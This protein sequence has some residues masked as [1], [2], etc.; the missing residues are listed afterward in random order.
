MS[1]V[2][3]LSRVNVPVYRGRLVSATGP[4]TR[5]QTA[6]RRPPSLDEC[7]LITTS[8]P[9]NWCPPSAVCCQDGQETW[10]T[11][12]QLSPNHQILLFHS[13]EF[14]RFLGFFPPALKECQALEAGRGVLGG[15]RRPVCSPAAVPAGMRNGRVLREASPGHPV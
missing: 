3:K 4:K 2:V 12:C 7:C 10:S 11:A 14:N 5:R 13:M 15:S 9:R 8:A 1:V 6:R